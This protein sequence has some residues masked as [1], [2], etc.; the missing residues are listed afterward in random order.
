[1]KEVVMT[2]RTL[3]HALLS[4]PYHFWRLARQVNL[5][6]N[7]ANLST[8]FITSEKY[9]GLFCKYTLIVSLKRLAFTFNILNL[10][11]G[12]CQFFFDFAV[13]AHK[14]I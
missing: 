8:L 14:W 12:N 11:D 10:I 9:E 5:R 6:A 4:T 7:L 3:F 2:F 1:M 13:D